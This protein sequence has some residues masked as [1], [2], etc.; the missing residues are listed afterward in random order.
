MENIHLSTPNNRRYLIYRCLTNCLYL[1]V[2][3]Q[4]RAFS[5]GRRLAVI[6]PR[7]PRKLF[8]LLLV[9]IVTFPIAASK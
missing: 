3:G 7:N 8:I 9:I 2:R 1:R 6:R 5:L 4:C